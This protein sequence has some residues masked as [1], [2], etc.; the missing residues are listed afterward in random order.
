MQLLIEGNR[1]LI[2]EITVK[3]M[4]LV[5]PEEQWAVKTTSYCINLSFYTCVEP[6]N[7]LWCIGYLN[8]TLLGSDKI[9]EVFILK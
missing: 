7:T 4:K 2:T 5:I 3:E 9:K 1:K 8:C 6:C